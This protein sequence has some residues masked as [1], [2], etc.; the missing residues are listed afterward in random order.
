MKVTIH[1]SLNKKGILACKDKDIDAKFHTGLCTQSKCLS[2][3]YK[4]L[5]NLYW[6][7]YQA[8]IVQNM[9]MFIE[10]IPLPPPRETNDLLEK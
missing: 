9:V 1:R 3:K 5:Q 10:D 7:E 6:V 4:L 8:Y 2:F